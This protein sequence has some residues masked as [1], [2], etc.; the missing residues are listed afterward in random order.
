MLIAGEELT[1]LQRHTWQMAEAFGMD[2]RIERYQGKRPIGLWR[3]DMD[4]LIAVV[5]TALDDPTEYPSKDSPGW[6]ALRGLHERL[7]SAYRSTYD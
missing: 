3:W 1:E 7:L 5:A 2:S 6:V 4:C